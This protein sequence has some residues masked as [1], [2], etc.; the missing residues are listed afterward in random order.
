MFGDHD[1]DRVDAREMLGRTDVALP[2]PS[3]AEQVRRAAAAG[4]E[5]MAAVPV[6]QAARRGIGRRLTRLKAGKQAH[7]RRAAHRRHRAFAA[8][9][10]QCGDMRAAGLIQ[11]QQDDLGILRQCGKAVPHQTPVVVRRRHQPVEPQQP[12]PPV[13]LRRQR[14]RIVAQRIGAIERAA[15]E[16]DGRQTRRDAHRLNRDRSA[17]SAR[18]VSC[19]TG[20]R[21][22]GK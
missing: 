19:R 8:L 1:D 14:R 12:R 11:P 4:A 16:P 20:Q 10:Q 7:Q 21:S 2:P 13:E 9:R 18:T 3:A 6:D 15:R 17:A 22:A 5:A